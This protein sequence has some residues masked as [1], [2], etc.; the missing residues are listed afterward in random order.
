MSDLIPAELRQ[1]VQERA[2]GRCEYC[3][4]HQDTSTYN[5]EIDHIVARK[6]GGQSIAENLALACLPCN[7]RKGS[8]LTTIDPVTGIVVPLFNPRV[9]RWEDHF[10]LSGAVI[11][12]LTP[13]GRG[14]VFLLALNMAD[15]LARRTTLVLE[16]LYP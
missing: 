12:G 6:H 9:Q 5:H 10:V 1:F 4:I 15:R 7:R 8:D 14:T 13:I 3:R 2:A 16:G 11:N